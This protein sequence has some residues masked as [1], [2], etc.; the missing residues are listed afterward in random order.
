ML[1]GKKSPMPENGSEKGLRSSRKEA[2]REPSTMEE[3]GT[4]PS[5]MVVFGGKERD[6]WC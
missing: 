3:G 4:V 5:R 6:H 1:G 2:S